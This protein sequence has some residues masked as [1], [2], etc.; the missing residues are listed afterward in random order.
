MTLLIFLVLFPLGVALLTALTSN[1]KMR[2]WIVKVS[3]GIIAVAT[4]ILT[5]WVL[6]SNTNYFYKIN[7]E[8]INKIMLCLELA[9]GI[10]VIYLGIKDKKYLVSLLMAMQAIVLCWIEFK[11]IGSI[12]IEYNLFIDKF[13]LIM[14]IL[15]GVI[16]SLICLYSVGYMHDYHHHH[17]EVKDKR[18]KFFSILFV[19]LSAMFGMVFSNNLMWLYFFWEITTLC[20]FLLIGYT[21]TEEARNNAYKALTLNVLGGLAF[22]LALAYLS[23]KVGILELN[24]MIAGEKVSVLIPAA[25]ICFAGLTKSAQMPFSSWLLGAMVAPTPSSALLH[26]STMVKAGVYVIIRLSPVLNDTA[27]GFLV[28][29]VGGFTFLTSSLIAIAQTDAKKVLAYSTIANLG[30]IVTCGGIGTY[31]SVWAAV[32]LIIFHAVAKSLLFLC[33]GT[34]EHNL[35][36]RNIEVMHGLIIKLPILAIMM[37]VGIAGM[38]LAPFG[39]LISKW[40]ALKAIVDTN[41][42]LVIF[43]AFGSAATLFFWTKWMGK[44]IAIPQN[45]EHMESNI[46]KSEILPMTVLSVAT[47]LVC[48]MFPFISAKLVNP[49]VIE[50]FE[51]GASMDSGNVI[52]MLI[53]MGLILLL[54]LRLLVSRKQMKEVSIYLGGANTDEPKRFYGSMG[55]VQKLY[56]E[57]YYLDRYFGEERLFDIGSLICAAATLLMLVMAIIY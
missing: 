57:N 54:P 52:I 11:L 5:V 27:A 19:F 43:I 41:P 48:L 24:R 42:I 34:V 23:G 47:I 17:K 15:V 6:K 1:N 37:I 3:A 13:S 32:L 14:A 12:E 38:F 45:E 25:L 44:I 56:I 8:A 40:A 4:L 53:M 2:G 31:E 36:S 26:S 22:A 33:V 28:A 16:G 50:V 7:F 55:S 51:H 9:I 18:K 10:Y 29:L 20:S 49:Y 46:K 39:M 30:L 21:N 35:G